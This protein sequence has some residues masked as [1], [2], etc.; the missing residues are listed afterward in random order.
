MNMK[1]HYKC[2]RQNNETDCGAA[3]LATICLFYGIRVE[4]SQIREL[5]CVDRHGANFLG[6]QNAADALGFSAEGLSG[7]IT[8]LITENPQSPYIAHIMKDGVL[9]HFVVVFRQSANGFIVG[10][11]A[12]GLVTYST[13]EFEKVWSGHILTLTPQKHTAKKENKQMHKCNPLTSFFSLVLKQKR[14][15][16]WIS[17]LSLA[18]TVLSIVA[19]F[20][21]YYLFDVIIPKSLTIQL[22]SAASIVAIVHITILALNLFRTRMIASLSKKINYDLFCNYVS[23]LLHINYKYYERYTTGDLI[24]R[25]QDTDAVR[26]TLSQVTITVSLDVVM[27]LAGITTLAILDWRL[28]IISLCVML[29]YGIAVASFNKPISNTSAEMREKD[30]STTNTFLETIHG[31]EDIKTCLFEESVFSKNE[32]NIH[33]LMEVFRHATVIYSIQSIIA[34]TIMSIGEVLVLSTGAIGVITGAMSIGSVIMFYSLFSMCI[35]PV[36]NIINL[37]PVVRK[38]EISAQRLQ[39][40][41][42]ATLE[43]DSESC[44]EEILLNSDLTVTEVSFRYGNRDLVLDRLSFEI[45]AGEHIALIGSSGSGKS[46]LIK[47]LLRL[48]DAESGK[49]YIGKRSIQSIPI[50]ALRSKIAYISQTAHL[51]RGSILDNICMGAPNV[52]RDD[53]ISFLNSTPYKEIISLFPM[54]Y[55]TIL[56][57]NGENLSGGQRQMIVVGRALVKQ[58]D[59]LIMDEATSAID[60]GARELI[61]T[62]IEKVYADKTIIVVSH[63]RTDAFPCN[64]SIL[65]ENGH[66]VKME[67]SNDSI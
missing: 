39:D 18:A 65:L 64:R 46:T 34:N 10:D 19:S 29:L 30:S 7:T 56:V 17:I 31:I 36:K 3:C 25:L 21:G 55:N 9:E 13:D 40:V 15:V 22:I 60:I 59:I 5:A 50:N 48:Y 42:S 52:E 6:L 47:L 51:F 26:E 14:Q 2:I 28:L 27:M 23:S 66:I 4:L 16:L 67:V 8:D 54:G 33:S 57:D 45:K 12:I 44:D 37:L 53:I 32:E 20:F 61:N 35:S 1:K 24:T 11:P 41:F 38:A 62:A 58:A 49:I 63:E 43:P